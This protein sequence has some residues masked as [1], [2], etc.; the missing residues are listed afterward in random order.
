MKTPVNRVMSGQER[1]RM[2]NDRHCFREPSG[3][4]AVQEALTW[5]AT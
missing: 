3:K 1:V 2:K 4:L 5:A